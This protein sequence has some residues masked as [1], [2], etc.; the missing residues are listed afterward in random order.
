MQTT[1][2]RIIAI[3]NNLDGTQN[4][5]LSNGKEQH[6]IERTN[7][8]Y[9]YGDIISVQF[10]TQTVFINQNSNKMNKSFNTKQVK[11]ATASV[12]SAVF[13]TG[14]FIF[15]SLAKGCLYAEAKSVSKLTGKSEKVIRAHRLKQTESYQR[16]VK[17]TISKA[18]QSAVVSE[19]K[20]ERLKAAMRFV[21]PSAEQNQQAV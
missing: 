6:W 8:V 14:H 2:F 1:D 12:A 20:M 21:G 18:R 7:E 15:D 3:T 4:Y 11:E 19:E 17:V 10:E 13:G 9:R 16:K 5:L